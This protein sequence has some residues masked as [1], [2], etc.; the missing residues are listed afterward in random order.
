MFEVPALVSVLISVAASGTWERCFQIDLAVA[1]G[2]GLSSGLEAGPCEE[3]A[4]HLAQE[5]QNPSGLK[6]TACHL[7]SPSLELTLLDSRKRER[8]KERR[9]KLPTRFLASGG[10]FLQQL[11]SASSYIFPGYGNHN[12]TRCE[13]EAARAL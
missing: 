9:R 12:G 11:L 6:N 3:P 2:L 5:H 1:S 7:P 8:E 4:L 10:Q 13:L